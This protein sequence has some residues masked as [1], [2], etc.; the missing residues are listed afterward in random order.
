MASDVSTTV[1]PQPLTRYQRYYAG[2]REERRAYG[3]A[4]RAANH[5][6]ILTQ[7]RAYE[8]TRRKRLRAYQPANPERKRLCNA[9]YYAAH[10]EA[11]RR[12]AR[13]YRQTHPEAGPTHRRQR[14]AAKLHAPVNN[15]THAQWGE[16][17]AAYD[18]RCVYCG[19]RRKGHL[20]QDHLTPL[21]KGGGHTASNV[22]P[23]CASCNSKKYTGPPLTPVQPLLLTISPARNRKESACTNYHIGS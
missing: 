7:R 5:E 3:H 12:R 21:S 2:H 23:A 16:I 6:K 8:A 15:L 14:R 4:Y 13:T 11:M 18:H 10:R 9:A 22:V 17:Q 20:T 1:P 19:T